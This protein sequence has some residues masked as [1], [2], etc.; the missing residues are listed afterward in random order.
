M[1]PT[2][3]PENNARTFHFPGLDGLRAIAAMTVVVLHFNIL[4]PDLFGQPGLFAGTEIASLSVTLFFVLSGFLITYLLMVEKE[5]YG[6]VSIKTFYLKRVL[7]IWP[8]YYLVVIL[9]LILFPFYKNIAGNPATNGELQQVLLFSVV[10]LPNIGSVLGITL[11]PMRPLWSIGVEEQFY[12]IWPWLVRKS[13]NIIYA[14]IGFI[15]LYVLLRIGFYFL[16]GKF[17]GAGFLYGFITISPMHIMA[18]GALGAYTVKHRLNALKYIYHP[19]AQVTCWG[20]Y[21]YSF[22]QPL[23]IPLIQQEVYAMIF[24]IIILNVA[25]NNKNLANIEFK[26]LKFLGKISYGLYV[27]HLLVMVA[28]SLILPHNLNA[29]LLLLITLVSVV[30]FSTLSYFYYERWFLNLKERLGPRKIQP[31]AASEPNL[32]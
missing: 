4:L 9:S 30:G 7:R 24:L 19:A 15:V 32:V 5:R 31:V 14:I 3:I 10:I 26:P 16:K 2:N 23:R 6:S 8:P 21:L 29:Y 25:T 20:V 28:L 22:Y 18:L 13:T 17:P 27:Y 12:A 11:T 1:N